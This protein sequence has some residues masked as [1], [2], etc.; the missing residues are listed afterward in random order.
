MCGCV[1][2]RACVCV[3]V[4]DE[5]RPVAL[6]Q[7]SYVSQ[8]VSRRPNFLH[9]QRIRRPSGVHVI[10]HAHT[11]THTHTH[12]HIHT[13]THSVGLILIYGLS[14]SLSPSL[15]SGDYV[16]ALAHYEKGMTRN[17]KVSAIYSFDHE[18]D[19]YNAL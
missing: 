1:C 11:H 8:E 10:V 16:N 7:R 19:V 2:V 14:K 15:C 17:D 6:G 9:L 12:T 5:K 18:H 13:H 4:L 3:C